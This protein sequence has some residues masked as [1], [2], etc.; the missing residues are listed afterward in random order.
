M[1]AG[2]AVT[3]AAYRDLLTGGGLAARLHELLDGIQPH[4][5]E[6]LMNRARQCRELGARLIHVST[7]CVFAGTGAG[8]GN[9]RIATSL[10]GVRLMQR[11]ETNAP[12]VSKRSTADV[13]R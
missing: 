3:A 10:G 2:F 8:M 4:E 7:D 11:S 13:A 9:A 12:R 5:T 1:P 6:D